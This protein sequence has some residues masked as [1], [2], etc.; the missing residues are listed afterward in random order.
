M[1]TKSKRLTTL[2][3]AT[4]HVQTSHEVDEVDVGSPVERSRIST[5][6]A[7]DSDDNCIRTLINLLDRAL[8]MSKYHLTIPKASSVEYADLQITPL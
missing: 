7:I 6:D 5:A 8:K 4:A 1:S 2:R 3:H